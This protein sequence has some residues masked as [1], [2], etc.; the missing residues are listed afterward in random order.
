MYGPMNIKKQ[1]CKKPIRNF[2]FI[3]QKEQ[4]KYFWFVFVA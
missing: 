2:F 4:E 1:N 3:V